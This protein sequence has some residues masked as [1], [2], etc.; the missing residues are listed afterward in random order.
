MKGIDPL[1]SRSVI[2]LIGTVI[3]LGISVYSGFQY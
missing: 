3:F 1:E 2:T